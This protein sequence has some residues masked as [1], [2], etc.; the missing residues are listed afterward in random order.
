MAESEVINNPNIQYDFNSFITSEDIKDFQRVVQLK[1]G[2]L[3]SP[4][5]AETQILKFLA[6]EDLFKKFQK[7][8]QFQLEKH[9]STINNGVNAHD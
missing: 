7:N 1:T 3:L 6:L 9:L 2:R 5:E 4:A 8:Q